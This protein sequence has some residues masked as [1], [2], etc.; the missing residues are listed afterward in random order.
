MATPW[1]TAVRWNVN[2]LRV[3]TY[4]EQQRRGS[5]VLASDGTGECGAL[6]PVFLVLAS[7]GAPA[8]KAKKVLKYRAEAS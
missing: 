8:P 3:K 7:A 1:E 4:V 6:R 5:F 2:R